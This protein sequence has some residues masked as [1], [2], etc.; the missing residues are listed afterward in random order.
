MRRMVLVVMA[1]VLSLGM[2]AGVLAQTQQ[3]VQKHPSCKYCGMDRQKFAHSRMQIVYEDGSS[4]GI[5]SLHCAAIELALVMDKTPKTIQV[6]DYKTKQLMDAETAIWV[7]DDKNPGVMTKRAKW[8]F[9][10]KEDAENHIK[11]HGGRIVTFEQA[12][13]ASYEDMYSDSKMIREKRKA[14]KTE[15]KHN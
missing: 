6:G 14:K 2:I 12:I 4:V 15:H 9:G 7:I 8:A 1:W 3:D 10:K 13:K 11:E 5:C